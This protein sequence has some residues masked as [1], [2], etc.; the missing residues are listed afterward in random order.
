[1]GSLP[2][3]PDSFKLQLQAVLTIYYEDIKG[4]QG[5]SGCHKTRI[6]K[7][8]F[9]DQEDNT[10]NEGADAAYAAA[11]AGAAVL[12]GATPAQAQRAPAVAGRHLQL[13]HL[14][15]ALSGRWGH[16]VLRRRLLLRLMLIKLVC[17]NLTRCDTWQQ[18]DPAYRPAS[19]AKKKRQLKGYISVHTAFNSVCT[20]NKLYVATC[21]LNINCTYHVHTCM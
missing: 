15:Q 17:L 18:P 21:T 11:G 6:F 13:L 12:P 4:V 5:A 16:W 20:F 14:P 19:R 10:D 1:M 3:M 9:K 8:L 2:L 7:R